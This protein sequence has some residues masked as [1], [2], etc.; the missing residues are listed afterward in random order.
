[1]K[2][3]NLKKIK[4]RKL[5][6]ERI[7]KLKKELKFLQ[8]RN[9]KHERQLEIE[10]SLVYITNKL[11]ERDEQVTQRSTNRFTFVHSE[12]GTV[13]DASKYDMKRK[14][15]LHPSSLSKLLSGEEVK[16]WRLVR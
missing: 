13:S 9:Y 14:Y 11:K 3:E 1:M 2:L 5:L 4:K 7:P 10:A 15:S 12:H 6:E 8:S 16:G